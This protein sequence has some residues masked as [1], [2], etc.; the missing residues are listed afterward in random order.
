MN[1]TDID[2]EKKSDDSSISHDKSRESDKEYEKSGE[3]T[4]ESYQAYRTKN[5][6]E[7]YTPYNG[8]G[9][10]VELVYDRYDSDYEGEQPSQEPKSTPCNRKESCC[11]KGWLSNLGI[12]TV[13]HTRGPKS[14]FYRYEPVV[15]KKTF[16][17]RTREA[18][19][20]PGTESNS[21]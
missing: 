8:T 16:K 17:T 5:L 20:L 10:A 21:Y 12:E 13:F 19:D 2:Q 1:S 18:I 6:P 15:L 14:N 7:G 11:K 4:E 3:S 9:Q